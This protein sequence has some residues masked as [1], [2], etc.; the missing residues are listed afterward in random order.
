MPSYKATPFFFLKTK[1]PFQKTNDF[2]YADA[3]A[4]AGHA[5]KEEPI[6]V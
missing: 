4:V 1:N 6:L 5:L 2:G 3:N